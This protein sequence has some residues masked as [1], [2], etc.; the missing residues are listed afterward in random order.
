MEAEG[1]GYEVKSDWKESPKL[2][3]L[4]EL[5]GLLGPNI[6]EIARRLGEDREIVS[7]HYRRKIL[8]IG[9]KVQA[10]VNHEKLGL[11]RLVII[12]SVSSEFEPYAEAIFSSMNE[13]CYVVGFERT[14]PEGLFI[15]NV[16]V[17]AE[18]YN[19]L[20]KFFHKLH[21]IGFFENLSAYDFDGFRTVPM[22]ARY[23]DFNLGRWIF[24]WSSG[25]IY[26]ADQSEYIIAKK[27]NFDNL[28]LLILKELQTDAN[29]KISDISRS[30]GLDYKNAS[31][32]YNHILA[33]GLLRGFSVNWMK[34][35]YDHSANRALHRRHKYLA[36]D[37][38]IKGIS[39]EE[40]VSITS[41]MNALPFLWAEA[42]GSNYY[43][44]LA[45]PI[46]AISDALDYINKIIASLRDRT[47]YYIIDQTNSLTFAIPYLLFDGA[48]GKW[49]FDGEELLKKFDE[50][51]LK[52]RRMS[53]ALP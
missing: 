36:I 3:E 38:F 51:I 35:S 18:H 42:W 16:S 9:L 48:K 22:K 37:L 45:F 34:T 24:D 2:A 53:Y 7:Y 11:K 32:H 52:I 17:P 8:D 44:Q 26:T 39:R 1:T 5:L 10:I 21:G 20:L 13:L 29:K 25:S 33:K 30:V 15:I 50:L 23:Y 12:A 4:V 43:A 6:D 46:E 40:R 28:D 47:K 49:R 27:V 31:L 41:A 14:L 19:A